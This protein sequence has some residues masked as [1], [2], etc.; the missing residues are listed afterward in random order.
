MAHVSASVRNASTSV[1]R[2][3]QAFALAASL[4]KCCRFWTFGAAL[5]VKGA[6]SHGGMGRAGRGSVAALWRVKS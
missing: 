3:F 4:Y 6:N 1:R 5:C 2:R